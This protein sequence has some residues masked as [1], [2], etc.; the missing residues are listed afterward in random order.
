MTDQELANQLF[1]QPTKGSNSSASLLT[2]TALENSSNG[3]VLVLVDGAVGGSVDAGILLPT[4]LTINAGDSVV[5][6]LYGQD[7]K[8][9]KALVSGRVG[10]TPGGD[11]SALE[12]RLTEDETKIT[13]LQ[14][15]VSSLSG[16]V[17]NQGNRISTLESDWGNYIIETWSNANQIVGKGVYKIG[18]IGGSVLSKWTGSNVGDYHGIC[19]DFNADSTSI[20]YGKMI[21]TSPRSNTIWEVNVWSRNI[22]YVRAI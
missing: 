8:G 9:K 19:W 17:T 14:V 22:D 21:V 16:T 18:Q 3:R 1:S 11:I 2:G 5:I 6:T 10:E 13:N 4:L 15:T 12:Q 7:G 20:M